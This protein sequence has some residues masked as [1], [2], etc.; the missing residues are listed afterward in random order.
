MS[1]TFINIHV[2]PTLV[3]FAVAP[4]D[5]RNVV[6]SEF[7]QAGNRVI[8]YSL[9][10]DE[11]ELPDFDSLHRNYSKIHELINEGKIVSASSVKIGG[12]CETI[13]NMCFGNKLGF[14]FNFSLEEGDL[15]RKSYGSMVMELTEDCED[16]DLEGLDYT[17]LGV[18][19]ENFEMSFEDEV[20]DG[21]KL[22]K[23]W[24]DKLSGI[25]PH[26]AKKN[27]QP[28]IKD[29]TYEIPKAEKK[30][31]NI[32]VAKPRV[33][34]PVFPGTNCEYETAKAFENAGAKPE[35]FVFKNLNAKHIEE[36]VKYMAEKI[37]N[38]QIIMIPGGFSG[39]DEP[40]GSGKFIATAF[41]NPVIKEAV[42]DM[43]KNRDGLMLGICNGFQALIK[44]GLVPY[45]EIRDTEE[46]AP[47]LTFN[48]IGRHISRMVYTRVNSTLSPWLWNTEAGEQFTV[49]VS[50]GD[51]RFVVTPE[52]YERL[53]ANHQIATQYCNPDG[54]A[55]TDPVW[56]PNGSYL[57]IEGIT[58]PDGHVLGKMAHSERIG[59]NVGKNV[60][61]N[62]DQQLFKSGVEY[63]K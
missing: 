15:F 20:L 8:Y 50:H 38:S 4:V 24:M 16:Y 13:S 17:D 25:F 55:D 3:S 59:E 14:L 12:L 28:E 23:V 39:G 56:S 37:N 7:K 21:E 5:V 53:A 54:M 35:I 60:P 26:T 33:F 43:L 10:H 18:V 41:R 30:R 29:S 40:D 1:G 57:A 36:S 42:M 61:G 63:F 9:P 49:P 31:A 27:D 62:K 32:S 46:T 22:L 47:T 34:I 11:N 52:E 19:S 51:G 58:S 44:L 2:P 6:S 48:T 45:G